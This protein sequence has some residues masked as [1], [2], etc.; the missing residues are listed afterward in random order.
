MKSATLSPGR[1]PP[2]FRVVSLASST[3]K[4]RFMSSRILVIAMFSASLAAL[5]MLASA[6]TGSTATTTTPQTTTGTGSMGSSGTS[7]GSSM[8]TTRPMN[9]GQ[10]TYQGQPM[11][12]GQSMNQGMDMSS[13]GSMGG[14]FNARNYR[15]GADCLNAAMAAHVALSACDSLKN[16]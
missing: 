10:P 1:N 6:Q 11:H 4:E 8:G 14:S 5:P 7:S 13:G 16:R 12:Q 9:Q 2:Q 3:R 15:T